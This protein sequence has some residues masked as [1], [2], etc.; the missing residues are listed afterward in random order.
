MIAQLRLEVSERPAL[1][2][3][4]A[5]MG[6]LSRPKRIEIVRMGRRAKAAKAPRIRRLT[7]EANAEAR[8]LAGGEG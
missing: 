5:A 8:R 7:R 4:I 6:K 3:L 2:N 1:G